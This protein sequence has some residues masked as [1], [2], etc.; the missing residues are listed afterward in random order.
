MSA[1]HRRILPAKES[2]CSPSPACPLQESCARF[3]CPLP[4][5]VGA[6]LSNSRNLV[7]YTPVGLTCSQFLSD[8][9]SDAELAIS[10]KKPVKPPIG[11]T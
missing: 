3:M 5:G 1:V 2:R 9:V 6:T 4:Q 10:A 8:M 11:S 7:I